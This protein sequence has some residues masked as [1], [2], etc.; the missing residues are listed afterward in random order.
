ME[1]SPGSDEEPSRTS[2]DGDSL[3]SAALSSEPTNTIMT[4]NSTDEPSHANKDREGTNGTQTTR[5]RGFFRRS[6]RL[7]TPTIGEFFSLNSP[8]KDSSGTGGNGSHGNNPNKQ[9]DSTVGTPAS[10]RNVEDEDEMQLPPAQQHRD[11]DW[12]VGDDVKM[13]LG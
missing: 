6:R 11:G 9:N 10:F 4:P 5:R 2:G 1:T 3:A 13:G 12:D 8:T 7:S